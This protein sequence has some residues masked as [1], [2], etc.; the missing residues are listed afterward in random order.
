[1]LIQSAPNGSSQFSRVE[2]GKG[3]RRSRKES[4]KGAQAAYAWKQPGNFY[5]TAIL[6]KCG[7]MSHILSPIRQRK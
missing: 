3:Q 7:L 1:M 2:V 5:A 4:R 6:A